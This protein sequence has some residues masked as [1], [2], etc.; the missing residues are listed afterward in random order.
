MLTEQ[1]HIVRQK[2]P[3][4]NREQMVHNLRYVEKLEED[5]GLIGEDERNSYQLNILK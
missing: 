1:T 4:A 2:A 5:K 3:T